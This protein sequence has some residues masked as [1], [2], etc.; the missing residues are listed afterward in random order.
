MLP[1]CVVLTFWLLFYFRSP[2]DW[3]ALFPVES[4]HKFLYS[5]QIVDYLAEH[6]VSDSN[7]LS[8][9][10]ADFVELGGLTSLHQIL[11]ARS[12]SA[13]SSVA[14]WSSTT[15]LLKIM[16]SFLVVAFVASDDSIIER[17]NAVSQSDNTDL[18]SVSPVAATP[19]VKDEFDFGFDEE[20]ASSPGTSSIITSASPQIESDQNAVE[21]LRSTAANVSPQLMAST[22]SSVSLVSL[23]HCLL[24]LLSHCSFPNAIGADSLC[25]ELT[26]SVRSLWLYLC[27]HQ[28][29][30]LSV[31]VS[32][33]QDAQSIM[34]TALHSYSGFARRNVSLCLHQLTKIPQ[35]EA[36]VNSFI[37]DALLSFVT[38]GT[39]SVGC[40]D[41]EELFALLSKLLREDSQTCSSRS[42]RDLSSLLLLL[43]GRL[44]TETAQKS[45]AGLCNLLETL[46]SQVSGLS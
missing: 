3:S 4:P 21:L 29:S 18:K 23:Q 1:D 42:A 8:Q 16:S 41:S 7:S 26:E 37:L 24:N 44:K 40:T 30:L 22:L 13:A 17:F 2:V 14:E 6:C 46:C 10:R 31:L 27:L 35:P 20:P 33:G 9:W 36:G 45:I 43:V 32:L 38:A 19:A 11:L 15:L 12:N 39:Q 28:P 5:L 34:C 25:A